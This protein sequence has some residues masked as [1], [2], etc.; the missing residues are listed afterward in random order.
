MSAAVAIAIVVR[1]T[2]LSLAARTIAV[3][4]GLTLAARALLTDGE[5]GKRSGDDRRLAFDARQ[6][7]ANQ[8]P[9]SPRKC[10]GLGFGR[11][12]AVH[13][14]GL[15]DHHFSDRDFSDR[16]DRDGWFS[17]RD[18]R[19]SRRGD[20]WRRDRRFDSDMLRLEYTR[21]HLV[22]ER[23]VGVFLFLHRRFR[24]LVRMFGLASR[25]PGQ[26]DVIP[27]HDHNGVV[28]NASFA[29]TVVVYDVAKTQRSLL[30][31]ILRTVFIKN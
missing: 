4:I 23:A 8:W 6:L 19:G 12:V 16:D 18:S 15:G 13:G 9:M 7:R 24:M 21:E 17:D 29:R 27:G 2:A 31:Q 10:G 25:A 1:L 28:S 3:V 26:A 30:H 20:F 11:R 14:C 5:I 22:V